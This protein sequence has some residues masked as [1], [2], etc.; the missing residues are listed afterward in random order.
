MTFQESISTCMGKYF[1]FSGRATRSEYWWFFLFGYLLTAV[2][3]IGDIHTVLI[4]LAHMME[5]DKYY[6]GDDFEAYVNIALVSL[7]LFIPSI[8]AISRRLHDIGRSGWWQLIAVT[9]IGIPVLV[10]WLVQES[11]QGTNQYGDA[12]IS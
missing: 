10:Y 4:E 12:P 2:A 3:T 5:H 9:G 7:I 6:L 1:T 8:S 11:A